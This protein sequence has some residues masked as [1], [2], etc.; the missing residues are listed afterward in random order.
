MKIKISNLII[1]FS[2]IS[3]SIIILLFFQESLP[4]SD[5]NSIFD[6]V[7]DRVK[8]NKFDFGLLSFL[9]YAA[10]NL[11]MSL[12]AFIVSPFMTK[13]FFVFSVTI[14]TFLITVNTSKKIFEYNGYTS[15]TAL[16]LS[17]LSVILFLFI[18][19][20][21][22]GLINTQSSFIALQLA[23]GSNTLFKPRFYFTAFHW[24]YIPA[25][26]LLIFSKKTLNFLKRLKFKLS[27]L[28]VSSFIVLFA[29][30]SLNYI[31][32]IN[33]LLISSVR[34]SVSQYLT[35][36]LSIFVIIINIIFYIATNKELY[37]NLSLISLISFFIAFISAK[38]SNRILIT[39]I[40][41][42]FTT[43][44][45]YILL[46]FKKNSYMFKI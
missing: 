29:L 46:I 28:I 31:G 15:K 42:D 40:Y 19:V 11:F 8:D 27:Q 21:I 17:N 32:K 12:F 20:G 9:P 16:I 13:S 7:L 45:S 26:G 14:I 2:I 39:L 36:Y 6:Y 24:V 41:Y 10:E 22:L 35:I 37:F 30:F 4:F 5:A 25:S 38:T 34:S 23:Y 1:I 3:Y 18:P 33:S 43:I 44:I